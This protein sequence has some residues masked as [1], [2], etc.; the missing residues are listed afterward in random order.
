MNHDLDSKKE[1]NNEDLIM[2]RV[3][4]CFCCLVF[5]SFLIYF[6]LDC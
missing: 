2:F 4:L 6:V 5:L 3:F 1:G